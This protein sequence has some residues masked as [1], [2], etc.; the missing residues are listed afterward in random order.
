MSK[1]L[2]RIGTDFQKH[3]G[4]GDI[5]IIIQVVVMKSK[6]EGY[7]DVYLEWPLRITYNDECKQN[8]YVLCPKTSIFPIKFIKRRNVRLEDYDK[9]IDFTNPNYLYEGCRPI[10]ENGKRYP[11]GAS[12]YQDY[13][14]YRNMYFYKTGE[15]PEIH[16]EKDKLIKPYILFHTRNIK[17]YSTDRNT[18]ENYFKF[19]YNIVKE[20]VGDKYEF[21]KCGEPIETIDKL[22]DFVA[23]YYART[24]FDNFFR[25]INNSS[26]FLSG[27]SGP[28]QYAWMFGIPNLYMDIPR[29]RDG[30]PTD[31]TEE[32]WK[33]QG[34]F[35]K[36]FWDWVDKEKLFIL[37]RDN[38]LEEEPVR[39]FIRKHLL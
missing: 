9:I 17:V 38:E 1:V 34:G 12:M 21:W 29:L 14:S 15:H 31:I 11:P 19:I 8:K 6:E 30:Q 10:Y 28:A 25:L 33:K 7:N 13:Y 23:P 20:E 16:I 24:N 4:S 36:T 22:F 35:G 18:N 3:M 2:F 39:M 37:W 26:M 27:A 5:G 32:S